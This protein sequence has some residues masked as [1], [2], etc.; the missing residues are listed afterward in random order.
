MHFDLHNTIITSLS[1]NNWNWIISLNCH[2][3]SQIICRIALKPAWVED[4]VGR[5]SI[6]IN[7]QK[8]DGLAAPMSSKLTKIMVISDAQWNVGEKWSSIFQTAH[9]SCGCSSNQRDSFNFRMTICGWP[10]RPFRTNL[11]RRCPSYI[12][13]KQKSDYQIMDEMYTI[14]MITMRHAGFCFW[15]EKCFWLC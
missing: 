7:W 5:W 8:P 4:R 1:S 6:C 9:M 3:L 11:M 13:A 12:H 2:K 15:L 14:V 10:S